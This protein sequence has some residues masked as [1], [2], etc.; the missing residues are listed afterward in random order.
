MNDEVIEISNQNLLPSKPILSVLMITYNHEKYI[1]QALDGVLS[2]ETSF[3]FEI[4]IGEDCSTDN[5]RE[6]IR[7]Y[8]NKYPE[9]IRLLI[10]E[11]NVG[12][13]K[14]FARAYAN[15]KGGYIALCD[16]DDYWDDDSKLQ[17]QLS[18]L[19]VNSGA[20]VAYHD[21]VLLSSLHSGNA[22]TLL[23]ASGKL[24]YSCEHLSKYEFLPTLT[25]LFRKVLK[26][27]PEEFFKVTNADTFIISM[28]GAYGSAIYV[29]DIRP[30]VYREHE[31][32]IWSG[33]PDHIKKFKSIETFYWLSG[34]YNRVGNSNLANHF[35]FAAMVHMLSTVAV[36]KVLLLKFFLNN[37]FVR[38]YEIYLRI[39]RIGGVI[40]GKGRM[41]AGVRQHK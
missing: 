21:V 17:K 38:I 35:I 19:L 9:K 36:E 11:K 32:G 1:A 14:N 33:I 29:A 22:I 10:S 26:D 20:V 41:S 16:G 24:G 23:T 4:V 13:N 5:T 25:M 27:L 3:P 39:K 6:V 37:Y 7:S 18:V 2:Q 34:Y 28:L 40:K 12:A 30:A 8:Q 31:G 15:C